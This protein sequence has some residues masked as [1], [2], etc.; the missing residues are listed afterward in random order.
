M[1]RKRGRGGSMA[2]KIYLEKAYD[3]LEWSFVR[4]TLSLFKIPIQLVTLIM[5]C[6]SSSSI[7]ILFNGGA[8][9]PFLSSRG[10]RQG[11]PLSPY[12]LILCMEVLGAFIADKCN[13]NH[14]NPI[15]VSQ[16]GLAFSHLFFTDDLVIFVRADRKNCVAIKEVLDSFC[17]IS[18]Q[19]VSHKKYCVF[20]SPDV[21]SKARA[22]LCAFQASA[23]LLRQGNTWGFLLNT[24]LYPKTLSSLLRGCKA[25]LLGG[26]LTYS[27]LQVGLF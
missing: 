4:D 10:L 15:K 26:K 2:I 18:G 11:D 23:L 20:F 19:K 17:S 6:I 27:P 8:L 24:H 9:E 21:S 5:S 7:S 14:Q 16:S 13:S 12:L 25:N 3:W 1:S 22:E